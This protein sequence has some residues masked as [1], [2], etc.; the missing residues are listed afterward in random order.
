MTPQMVPSL[1]TWWPETHWRQ[2]A[3]W[4]CN[5]LYW[6]VSWL[7]HLPQGT[8]WQQTVYSV[9]SAS[10]AR[11]SPFSVAK[12]P[13][14]FGVDAGVMFSCF[15]VV[16][17]IV[18]QAEKQSWI[19]TTSAVTA[20]STRQH[21]SLKIRFLVFWCSKRR[22]FP[23]NV[24]L[25]RPWRVLP[26]NSQDTFTSALA[27]R[28][29]CVLVSASWARS[30][31]RQDE[32]L[33]TTMF[34]V[35]VLGRSECVSRPSSLSVPSHPP[36]C[37]RVM[38]GISCFHTECAVCR[39]KAPRRQH[40]TSRWF[41]LERSGLRAPHQWDTVTTEGDGETHT[42]CFRLRC[43][44]RLCFVNAQLVVTDGRSHEEACGE[45]PHGY[46][47]QQWDG[48]GGAWQ[49]HRW[50]DAAFSVHGRHFRRLACL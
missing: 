20:P 12:A 22:V 32:P 39:G 43:L 27:L 49:H 47:C 25:R 41:L 6:A 7:K 36:K 44:K 11:S 34:G 48:K 29:T 19:R 30:A 10:F 8:L 16:T 9:L 46:W 45:C 28:L 38:P 13:T 2:F 1:K 42:R 37:S 33:S 5:P 18:C 31:Q 35:G 3:I 23:A 4:R 21:K 15:R 24:G 26:G 14:R 50:H 40:T 17:C